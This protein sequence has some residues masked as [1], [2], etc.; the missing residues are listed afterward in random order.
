MSHVDYINNQR[1]DITFDVMDNAKIVNN[2]LSEWESK[3]D[4]ENCSLLKYY[5]NFKKVNQ[6]LLSQ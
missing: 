3:L 5:T 2:I 4:I 6:I 1:N